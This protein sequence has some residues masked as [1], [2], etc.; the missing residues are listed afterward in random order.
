MTRK[1]GQ[2]EFERFDKAMDALLRVSHADLKAVL[3]A[4]KK[5]KA[6]KRAKSNAKQKP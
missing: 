3:D 1:T 2:S 4:E 5:A 6:E